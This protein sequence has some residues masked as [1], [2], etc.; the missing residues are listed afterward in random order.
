MGGG[1]LWWF[2]YRWGWAVGV[3]LLIVIFEIL[4]SLFCL[5]FFFVVFVV[6]CAF[7]FW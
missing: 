7:W 6:F 5:C 2:F 3:A 4:G 1:F